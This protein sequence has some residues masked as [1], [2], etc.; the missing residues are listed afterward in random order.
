MPST[1]VVKAEPLTPEAFRDYGQVVGADECAMELRDGEVFHLNVLSYERKPIVV[2]HLNRHHKAT[3]MLV[4]LAGKPW[5]IVCG[6]KDLDLS[7]TEQLS[8]LRAF[9]CDGSAGINLALGTWHEGPF[10]LYDRVDL[11]NV[12]GA[13]VDDDNEVAHLARDLDV[14]LEVSL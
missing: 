8:R 1:Y 3:Q 13:H 14:V 4:S 5:V 10:P 9:I 7:D 12:Q 6:S 2:D 11:V